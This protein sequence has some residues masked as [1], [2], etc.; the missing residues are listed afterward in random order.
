[1]N[2]T[3]NTIPVTLESIARQ[4]AELQ[5]K[6][7]LQKEIMTGLTHEIFAPLRPATNKGNA[8]MRTFN[9]GMAIFDGIEKKK[10]MMKKFKRFFGR[11]K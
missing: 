3:T 4:K 8:M 7:R 9:T 11:K 6:I 1:M 2:N 5:Q 10:K